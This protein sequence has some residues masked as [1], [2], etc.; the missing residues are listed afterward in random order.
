MD[1]LDPF[2]AFFR[3]VFYNFSGGIYEKNIGCRR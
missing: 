1:L 2:F 3:C